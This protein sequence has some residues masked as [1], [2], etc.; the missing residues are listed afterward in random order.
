MSSR[1]TARW[2][3]P[4]A[5]AGALVA[6]IV[7]ASAGGGSDGGGATRPAQSGSATTAGGASTAT[8]TTPTTP[9]KRRYTVQAGDVLS[10]IA[11]KTGVPLTEIERLNPD[12]DAQSLHAGQKIKLAP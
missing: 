1:L 2:L 10:A 6:V 11:E 8:S 12:V 5:L 9:A 3:A 4:A 7:V